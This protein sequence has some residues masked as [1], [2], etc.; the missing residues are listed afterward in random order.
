[1]GAESS[2][3]LPTAQE[4]CCSVCDIDKQ[5]EVVRPEK[6]QRTHHW[7]GIQFSVGKDAPIKVAEG[8]FSDELQ[9]SDWSKAEKILVLNALAANPAAM[10]N[11]QARRA[12]FEGLKENG[13][14]GRKT[15]YAC[16]EYG[17]YLAKQAAIYNALASAEYARH[18]LPEIV[19][20]DGRDSFDFATM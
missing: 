2:M 16:E 8:P 14:L 3:L 11:S 19:I 9:H 20:L 5:D 1:M 12:L 6:L 15:L 10:H 4:S 7:E 18:H 17:N 13:Q